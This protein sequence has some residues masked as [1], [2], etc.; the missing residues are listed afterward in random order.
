MNYISFHMYVL[1]CVH[2]SLYHR[3]Y[4]TFTVKWKCHNSILMNICS[5]VV[6]DPSRNMDYGPRDVPILWLNPFKF[7]VKC[8]MLKYSSTRV[9]KSIIYILFAHWGHYQRNHMICTKKILKRLKDRGRLIS[10][11]FLVCIWKVTHK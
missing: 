9:S 6:E 7:F 8:F 10:I 4:F 11:Y 3:W 1:F 2:V 5:I